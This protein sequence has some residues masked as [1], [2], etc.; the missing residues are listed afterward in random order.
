MIR[1]LMIIPLLV[2]PAAWA[3]AQTVGPN[4]RRAALMET[5]QLIEKRWVQADRA[6][7]IAKTLR[8]DAAADR[9]AAAGSAVDF[10]ALV[11]TRLRDISGDGHFA[12]RLRGG[13]DPAAEEEQEELDRWYGPAVNHGFEHV[14]RLEGG[15]GYLDLRVFAPVATASDLASSAMNLLAESPALIIDLRMNGGGYGDMTRLLAAYLLDRRTE[16]S[17]EFD[18]PTGRMARYFTPARVPGRRFGGSKPVFILVSKRTFSAAEAFAYDLQAMGRATIVGERTG[19]GAHPYV[20]HRVGG[21]FVLA[22]PEAR[23]VNPITKTDWEGT[24]VTPDV[25]VDAEHALERALSLADT[26]RK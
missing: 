18:R 13:A 4:D 2:C 6:A 9:F 23:S 10:A 25:A 21:L 8:D 15:V 17:G 12:L 20:D 14:G 11:T 3:D 5:A 22:L 7:A 26:K 19:G 1:L 24:G 16:M